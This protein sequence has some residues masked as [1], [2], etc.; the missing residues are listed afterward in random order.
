MDKNFNGDFGSISWLRACSMALSGFQE[1][2][3]RNRTDRFLMQ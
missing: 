1:T 3:D 2:I